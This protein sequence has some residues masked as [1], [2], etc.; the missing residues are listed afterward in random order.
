MSAWAEQRSDEQVRR[1]MTSYGPCQR[2]ATA[3]TLSGAAYKA[4]DP[5]RGAVKGVVLRLVCPRCT[6]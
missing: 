2:C 5:K 1:D 4:A 6:S 3:R